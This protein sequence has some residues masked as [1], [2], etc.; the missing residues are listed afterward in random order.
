MA[1]RTGWGLQEI[2]LDSPG[3]GAPVSELE[4]KTGDQRGRPGLAWQCPWGPSVACPFAPA[5][6][7]P[8]VPG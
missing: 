6:P 5:Q 2:Q 8:L 1:P 3:T 7:G 4:R